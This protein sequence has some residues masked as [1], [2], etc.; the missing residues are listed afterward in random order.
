[1]TINLTKDLLFKVA[2]GAVL[3]AI[4]GLLLWS[5][6]WQ[7]S[8]SDNTRKIT[9][10]GSASV[11]AE[12]DGYTFN[13]YFEAKG[14]DKDALKTEVTKKANA[15]I[16]KLKEIG[17]E[18]KDIT[19]DVSSYDR[20]YWREGQ[21][22]NL[23][24][25]LTIRTSDKDKAQEIQNYLLSTDAK[26]QLTSTGNFS[27]DK[28]KQL[29]A[30]AK[31]KAIEDAKSKAETQAKS[32]DAK[33]GKVITVADDANYAVEPMMARGAAEM[34]L[35]DSASTDLPV[36]NGQDQVYQTVTV[37]YELK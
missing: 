2:H 5:Q 12:P 31:N 15:A 27:E 21:D 17:V 19:L 7:N 26:G 34:S 13:P 3:V 25:Y 35:D 22:G 37:T 30:D 33:L 1:M 6:P 16:D 20:W 32:F 23:S 11:E 8:A 24:A 14:S 10:S 4:L 28:L 18:D 9:V 36:L 29:Q